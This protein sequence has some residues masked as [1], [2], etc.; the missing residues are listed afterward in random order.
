MNLLDLFESLPLHLKCSAV[1]LSALALV[2]VFI[3]IAWFSKILAAV[4]RKL[5]RRGD[6]AKKAL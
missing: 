5:A 3:N 2:H 1:L 6:E 4:R